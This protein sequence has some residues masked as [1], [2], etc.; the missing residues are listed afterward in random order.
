MFLFLALTKV[1]TEFCL[2]QKFKLCIS[3]IL[4]HCLFKSGGT[5]W[6]I[7]FISGPDQ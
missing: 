4:H 2:P 1:K 3:L 7:P 5:C 6:D